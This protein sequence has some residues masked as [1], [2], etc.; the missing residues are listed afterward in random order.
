[1]SAIPFGDGHTSRPNTTVLSCIAEIRYHGS[2]AGG[3]GAFE[4]VSHNQ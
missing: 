4:C 1:M 3:R 2:D